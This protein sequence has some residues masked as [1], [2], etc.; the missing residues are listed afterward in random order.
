VCV[1]GCGCVCLCVCGGGCVRVWV[2]KCRG[3][4]LK[5]VCVCVRVC[6]RV[7]VSVPVCVRAM[8]IIE[9]HTIGSNSAYFQ[10]TLFASA[11]SWHHYLPG[12]FICTSQFM[13]PLLA[14]LFYLHQPVP[15]TITCRCTL[16]AS[17]S[18]W[19]HYLPGYFTCVS[20]CIL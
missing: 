9:V 7:C 6:V 3:M 4:C 12:Y 20:Q 14:R 1:C 10:V 16:L 15:D 13:A 17:A 2:F 11:S 19:H 8:S 5:C 18:S